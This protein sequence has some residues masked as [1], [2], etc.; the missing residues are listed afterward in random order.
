MALLISADTVC[1]GIDLSLTHTMQE[2]V[3]EISSLLVPL[4]LQPIRAGRQGSSCAPSLEEKSFRY[5]SLR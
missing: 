4:F 5:D 3:P 1:G 2:M